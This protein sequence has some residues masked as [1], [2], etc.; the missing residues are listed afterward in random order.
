MLYVIISSR[1][2]HRTGKRLLQ[3]TVSDDSGDVGRLGEQ[4]RY[5][6]IYFSHNLLAHAFLR[7]LRLTRREANANIKRPDRTTC[8]NQKWSRQ[9]VK[10]TWS[11]YWQ[12]PR[13]SGTAPPLDTIQMINKET[14]KQMIL[15]SKGSHSVGRGI[16]HDG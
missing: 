15:H 8:R 1:V 11:D 10:G 13:K 2:I 9:S 14:G 5:T 16:S 12:H 6:S 7:Y 3:R 4:P